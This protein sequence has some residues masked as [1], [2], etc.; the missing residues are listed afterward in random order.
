MRRPSVPA[1]TTATDLLEKF[2]GTVKLQRTDLGDCRE[3]RNRG[4]GALVEI[5]ERF[6][7]GVVERLTYALFGGFELCL[8]GA[9][10][11]LRAL[12]RSLCHA[13]NS[14][15]ER[16]VTD[17]EHVWMA[18][19][20]QVGQDVHAARTVDLR[21]GLLGDLSTQWTCGHSGRPN[22]AGGFDATGGAVGVL[23]GQPLDVD[24]DDLCAQLDLDAQFL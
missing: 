14:G 22:L 1:P 10:G 7:D 16:H 23:D 3:P 12:N 17:H 20:C 5:V 6:A 11:I 4:H 13:G 19:N 2:V 18:G 8:D 9:C 15:D 24:I 21:A